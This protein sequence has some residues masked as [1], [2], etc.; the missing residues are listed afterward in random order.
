MISE[1]KK[2]KKKRK[3]GISR[4]FW[5]MFTRSH[6]AT[7][8][9]TTGNPQAKPP[10]TPGPNDTGGA[11]HPPASPPA[12]E[13]RQTALAALR[14][15]FEEITLTPRQ[16]FTYI[17]L[18]KAVVSKL[19]ALQEKMTPKGAIKQEIDHIT[20]VYVPKA[21]SDVDKSRIAK[22]VDKLR[23]I[24]AKQRSIKAKIQ[25]WAYFDGAQK[26]D[27]PATAL[28]GLID[29]PGLAELHCE[30]KAALRGLGLDPSDAHGFTPHITICYLEQGERVENL[31]EIG[32]S[33]TIDKVCFANDAVH[34]MPLGMVAETSFSSAQSMA[35]TYSANPA[36]MNMR[37]GGPTISGPGFGVNPDGTIPGI[38]DFQKSP[39]IGF[40]SEIGWR[41][42]KAAID[43]M[44][45]NPTLQGSGVMQAAVSR[46]GVRYG[47]LD[48]QEARLI[49]MGI[50]WYCA[51]GAGLTDKKYG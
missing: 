28:V 21:E 6:V 42:W 48:A 19:E 5:P 29:A 32:A 23:G 17:P 3:D 9:T 51:S 20:M 30:L 12:P 14:G 45:S 18:P 47:Q 31:P 11:V 46:A 7:P 1:S 38:Y 2:H 37:N 15:M 27:K 41:I 8:S 36:A 44:S 35:G 24:C 10:S 43:I 16:Q 25:G 39:G 40:K 4:V 33:F 50:E 49:E 13:S 34:E 26:D 22:V